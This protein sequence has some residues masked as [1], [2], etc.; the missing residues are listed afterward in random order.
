MVGYSLVG[1]Q[2]EKSTF[3]SVLAPL[4]SD[5][6]WCARLRSVENPESACGKIQDDSGDLAGK[7]TNGE[8]GE[9]LSMCK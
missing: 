8:H 2:R 1:G 3:C 4:Q 6:P 7:I 5:T 9:K